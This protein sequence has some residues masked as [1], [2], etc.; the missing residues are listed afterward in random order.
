[1]YSLLQWGVNR[2]YK[3]IINQSPVSTSVDA[4]L[5]TPFREITQN[6]DYPSS[7]SKAC[8][9]CVVVKKGL[10]FYVLEI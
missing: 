10:V 8:M 9:E 7:L 2:V 5:L 6:A 3:N 1:M 4:N